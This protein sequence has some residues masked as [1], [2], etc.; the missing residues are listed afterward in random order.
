MKQWLYCIN[1]DNCSQQ[2]L[3][4][5]RT[6]NFIKTHEIVL[7]MKHTVSSCFLLMPYVQ[8]TPEI[9]NLFSQFRTACHGLTDGAYRLTCLLM[10]LILFTH[11]SLLFSY[12]SC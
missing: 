11:N 1:V 3:C 7:E 10:N 12:C 5:L 4:G 6:R 2:R 9:V 8:I